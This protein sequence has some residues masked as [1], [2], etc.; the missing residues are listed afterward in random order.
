M[1]LELKEL[2]SDAV[3]A[4]NVDLSMISVC[5][6]IRHLASLEKFSLVSGFYDSSASK[7]LFSYAEF[8]RLDLKKF[9]RTCLMNAQPYQISLRANSN[10]FLYTMDNH[11]SLVIY[12][13][14]EPS[15]ARSMTISFDAEASECY[16]SKKSAYMPVFVNNCRA[17]NPEMGIV[18]ADVSV[19]R[20]LAVMS[21]TVSARRYGQVFIARRDDVNNAL[22][23]YCSTYMQDLYTS[24]LKFDFGKVDILSCIR[25]LS[26]N[27]YSKDVVEMII[28]LLDSLLIQDNMVTRTT[29][30]FALVT[31]LGTIQLSGKEF[32]RLSRELRKHYANSDIPET[33]I[34]LER[35]FSVIHPSH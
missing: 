20:G 10:A 14:T 18:A 17:H 11:Y 28:L 29:A 26:C 31:Y 15:R 2:T 6:K 5:E 7:H 30:D 25:Q 27:S 13:G 3:K 33:P 32:N 1:S 9:I 4:L 21:I 35:V 19:Q 16:L 8:C 34:L 23:D 12:F 22:L 24:N